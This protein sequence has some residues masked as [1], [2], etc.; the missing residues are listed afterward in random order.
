[1]GLYICMKKILLI[2]LILLTLGAIIVAG[3]IVYELT[4]PGNVVVIET[5]SG[6][7]EVKVYEDE[8]CTIPLTNFDFGSMGCAEIQRIDFYIKNTGDKDISRVEVIVDSP[9]NYMSGDSCD[10]LAV[11]QSAS[12]HANL[13]INP[14]ASAGSY[15]ANVKITCFA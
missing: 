14:T 15:H 4:I 9:V 11:G 5:P 7:Y 12:V 8:A 10:N 13:M 1:M 3:A 2:F 6:D